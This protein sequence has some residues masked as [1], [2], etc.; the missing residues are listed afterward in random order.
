V[1]QNGVNGLVGAV[2]EGYEQV[3]ELSREFTAVPGP[4]DKKLRSIRYKE[5]KPCCKSDK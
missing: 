5:Y 4:Y 1:L 3:E 2:L